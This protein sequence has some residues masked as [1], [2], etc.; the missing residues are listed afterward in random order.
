L[1]TRPFFD[2]RIRRYRAYFFSVPADCSRSACCDA[3]RGFKPDKKGKFHEVFLSGS[4]LPFDSGDARL[5]AKTIRVPDVDT[6][7]IQEGMIKAT[8]GDT[9]LVSAGTHRGPGNRD[10][11]FSGKAITVISVDGSSDTV[12]DCENAGG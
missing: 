6:A 3:R 9:V 8:D 7:T 1:E 2:Y 5:H 12:I 10:L 4:F 11:N